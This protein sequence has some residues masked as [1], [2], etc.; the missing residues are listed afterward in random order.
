MNSRPMNGYS[1]NITNKVKISMA[2]YTEQKKG[3]KRLDWISS[4]ALL[5]KTV[6]RRVTQDRGLWF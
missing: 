5:W 4:Q 1:I 3:K 2:F 6:L